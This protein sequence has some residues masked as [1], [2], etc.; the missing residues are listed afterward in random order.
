MALTGGADQRAAIQLEMS[1][2]LRKKRRL[3]MFQAMKEVLMAI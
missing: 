2:W 3:K 1:T